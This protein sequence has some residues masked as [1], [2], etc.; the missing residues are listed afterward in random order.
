MVGHLYPAGIPT[1]SQRCHNV[2][3]NVGL[4][5][6]RRRNGN[7]ISTSISDVDPTSDSDV[8]TTLADVE[9]R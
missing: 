8:V 4:T 9:Q 7:V 2:G 1:L 3:F 5:L 6:D